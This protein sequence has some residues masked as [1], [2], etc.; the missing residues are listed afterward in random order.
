[1]VVAA[2]SSSVRNTGVQTDYQST[3]GN[4]ACNPRTILYHDDRG[5]G[6]LPAAD[7][8]AGSDRFVPR[9]LGAAKCDIECISAADGLKAVQDG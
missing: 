1:M 2:P 7:S 6:R 8:R 4:G 5:V 3:V 9:A